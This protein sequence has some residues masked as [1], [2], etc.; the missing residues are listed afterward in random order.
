MAGAKVGSSGG[1]LVDIIL[2]MAYTFILLFTIKGKSR[3]ELKQNR[4]Q[5]ARP[6]A[7]GRREIVAYWLNT[8]DLLSRLS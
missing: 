2:P 4:N 3:Q 7:E 5:E 8:S 1:L 6:D